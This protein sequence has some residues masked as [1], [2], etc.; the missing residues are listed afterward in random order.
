[1]KELKPIQLFE[2]Y[3]APV[4]PNF[5]NDENEAIDWLVKYFELDENDWAATVDRK[6]FT[7]SITFKKPHVI[8]KFRRDGDN[9]LI[10][11]TVGPIRLDLDLEGGKSVYL[12]F[13]FGTSDG[14]FQI[15]NVRSL[16]GCPSIVNGNF[17]INS[18]QYFHSVEYSP[19]VVKGNY[20]CNYNKLNHL[21][22]I[23]KYIG[24]TL[25]LY[26]TQLHTNTLYGLDDSITIEGDIHG[27]YYTIASG[28]HNANVKGHVKIDIEKKKERDIIVSGFIYIDTPLDFVC[29]VIINDI[30]N[31]STFDEDKRLSIYEYALKNN[32][33]LGFSDDVKNIASTALKG[34]HKLR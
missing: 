23:S 9:N 10:C 5:I 18:N 3:I 11:D 7:L 30:V 31:I 4:E 25:D 28:N 33:D 14:D 29:W 27:S 15:C 17:N 8:F 6:N 1:M 26:M 13:R 24:G 21:K 22:G 2:G 19:D 32:I 12:P 20:Y 34:N 16:I